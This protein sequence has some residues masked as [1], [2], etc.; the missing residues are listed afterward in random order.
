LK[1]PQKMGRSSKTFLFLLLI[2]RFHFFSQVRAEVL[3][4]S[5][6]E[7]S[8]AYP[9]E[10]VSFNDRLS[11]IESENRHQKHEM[12]LLKKTVD[13]DKKT[14]AHLVTALDEEKKIVNQLK[15]RIERLEVSAPS[16]SP[17]TEQVILQIAMSY[18]SGIFQIFSLNLGHD[19][20]DGSSG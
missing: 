19:C 18:R 8:C 5:K 12:S 11:A 13:D 7:T 1:I 3:N 6:S 2:M 10:S 16:R 4:E 15:G 20:S 14:I 17:S 9:N